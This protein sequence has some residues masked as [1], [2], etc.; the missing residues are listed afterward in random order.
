MCMVMCPF[1][2]DRVE[3]SLEYTGEIKA[4]KLLSITTGNLYS[5]YYTQRYE[6]GSNRSDRF[7]LN[8]NRDYYDIGEKKVERGIHVFL[9]KED[10]DEAGGYFILN[11]FGTKVAVVEVTCLKQDF[12]GAGL[13]GDDHVTEQAVFMSVELSQEEHDRAIAET[14]PVTVQ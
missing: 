10:A 5:P 3:K 8:D 7:S 12:V 4:Y 11:N 6:A 9:T 1:I 2:T 14:N 13:W